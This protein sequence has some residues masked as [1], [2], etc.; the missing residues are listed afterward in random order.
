MSGTYPRVTEIIRAAGMMGDTSW[1]TEEARERGTAVHKACHYLCEGDLDLATLDPRVAPRVAQFQR[2][3]RESG[4]EVLGN[5]VPVVNDI[6]RYRGTRD[7]DV[8]LAGRLAI[9]DIKCGPPMPWHGVQLAAYTMTPAVKR[10]GLH[11]NDT[12]YKF[13]EHTDRDDWNVFVAAVSL[14]NWRTRHG[15]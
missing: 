10:Y 7:L 1:Y 12:G 8:R 3:L 13:I 9:V 6:Y 5:E 14:Y 11:L 4:A 15:V 2:W